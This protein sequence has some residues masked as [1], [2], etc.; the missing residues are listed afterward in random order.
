MAETG[1]AGA[2]PCKPKKQRYHNPRMVMA[3]ILLLAAAMVCEFPFFSNTLAEIRQI[4]SMSGYEDMVNGMTKEE[5]AEEKEKVRTYNEGIYEDQM[6]HGFT[7]QGPQATD[8]VYE[9]LLVSRDEN[10]DAAIMGII[11]I[12][13]IDVYLPIGHGTTDELLTY[14]AGH[15]YGSS[16]P[17]GGK[18]TNAIIAGHTGLSTARLFTDV[19]KLKSGDEVRIHVLDEI[20]RYK[21]ASKKT[22]KQGPD[23]TPLLQMNEGADEI[24]LYTCSPYGINDERIILRAKR[25]YPDIPY[26]GDG[27][28]LLAMSRETILKLI[29]CAAIPAAILILS[30]VLRH[31]NKKAWL[32]ELSKKASME[33]LDTAGGSQTADT[34]DTVANTADTADTKANSDK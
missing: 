1:G 23:E 10:D 21:I 2:N 30:L 22:V 32:A 18:N 5:I 12:P 25:A 31:K 20:H 3:T 14:A 15:M 34:A 7:Y 6:L 24:T 19:K 11:E 17:L 27:G 13:I 26:D 28:T 4:G 29:L 33:S 16:L 9:S 8:P